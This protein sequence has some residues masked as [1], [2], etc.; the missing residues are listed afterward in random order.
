MINSIKDIS[1]NE[2]TGEN[3]VI[4]DVRSPIEFAKGHLLE[5]FNVPLFSDKEREDIGTL[6]KQTGKDEAV[7]K[8]LEFVGPKMG[9]FIDEVR[10]I[11][12]SNE[13]DIYVYC[14]RG[15]M[16][17]ESFVW[18]L[19]TAGLNACKISGG[20]KQIKKIIQDSFS[21]KYKMIILGGLTGS[22]KTHYLKKLGESGYQILDLEKMAN[23]KGSAFGHINEQPQPTN[24]QFAN[25]IYSVWKKFDLDKIVVIEDESLKVG[26]VHIP[27]PLYSQMKSAPV[28]CINVPNEVRVQQLLKDYKS[29]DKNLL[30]HACD[31]IKMKLGSQI[32]LEIIALIKNDDIE[33]ACKKLLDYYDKFYAYGLQKRTSEQLL[34]VHLNASSEQENLDILSNALSKVENR[35]ARTI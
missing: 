26:D 6:Y 5:A 19:N 23:H 34:E 21:Q 35:V 18:L 32:H 29:T 9:H 15:G 10:Q 1:Y 24:E 22:G 7:K 3:H 12:K 2:I 17:S 16:R 4:I 28:I 30:I 27:Q 33:S 13:K 25:N 20:Y 11:S 31:S 14:F 8:G